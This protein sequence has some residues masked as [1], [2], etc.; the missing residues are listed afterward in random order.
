[1]SYRSLA[2]PALVR[3]A[4]QAGTTADDVRMA[5]A[6]LD[7]A[8][9]SLATE[10]ARATEPLS[11]DRQARRQAIRDAC[12]LYDLWQVTQDPEQFRPTRLRKSGGGR[13]PTSSP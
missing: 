11:V 4:E 1:M 8:E 5:A 13:S 6:H 12:E 7:I 10:L 3:V 9:T 2:T